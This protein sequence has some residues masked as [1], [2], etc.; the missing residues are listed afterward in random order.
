MPYFCV[1]TLMRVLWSMLWNCQLKCDKY[2]GTRRTNLPWD[3]LWVSLPWFLANRWT[4]CSVQ[5]SKWHICLS[6]HFPFHSSNCSFIH[7]NTHPSTHFRSFHS[8][9]YLSIHPSCCPCIIT[10]ILHG[11]TNLRC[12]SGMDFWASR[13]RDYSDVLGRV[14]CRVTVDKHH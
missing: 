13:R 8:S 14:S 11:I 12:E 5:L 3:H 2:P 6:T 10:I 4:H 7:S 9:I 1:I